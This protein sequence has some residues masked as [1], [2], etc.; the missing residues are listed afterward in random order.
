MLVGWE[1]F[2]EPKAAFFDS[3]WVPGTGALGPWFVKREGGRHMLGHVVMLG[4][5]GPCWPMLVSLG[6]K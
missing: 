2:V 3:F 1:A 6:A 4:H 5:V